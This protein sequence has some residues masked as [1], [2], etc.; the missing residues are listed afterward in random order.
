MIAREVVDQ[1]VERLGGD[2]GLHMRHQ[3]VEALRDQRTGLAHACEGGGAVQLDLAGFAERR[4]RGVNVTHAG[5]L[6]S[7]GLGASFN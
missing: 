6:R 7:D 5:N 2:A 3:H 1:F 4:Q